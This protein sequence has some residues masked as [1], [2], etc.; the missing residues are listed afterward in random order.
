MYNHFLFKIVLWL[1]VFNESLKQKRLI[2][3][4][5]PRRDIKNDLSAS[6]HQCV[7]VGLHSLLYIQVYMY[8]I[9]HFSIFSLT[10][11]HLILKYD[12]CLQAKFNS[13]YMKCIR[14]MKK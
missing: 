6:A 10:L 4:F 12:L 8:T 7:Y 1:K 14:Y 5:F 13:E 3:G 9:W 2:R 11:E